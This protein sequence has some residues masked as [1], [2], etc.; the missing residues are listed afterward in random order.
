M[1]DQK[2]SQMKKNIEYVKGEIECLKQELQHLGTIPMNRRNIVSNGEKIIKKE[3]ELEVFEYFLKSLTTLEKVMDL[4]PDLFLQI[5]KD[6]IDTFQNKI[7]RGEF[8]LNSTCQFKNLATMMNTAGKCRALEDLNI[9][10][11]SLKEKQEK[12]QDLS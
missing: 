10:Y 6:T 8:L 12:E 11:Q 2:T 9:F 5:L 7:L 3:G 4:N 1:E